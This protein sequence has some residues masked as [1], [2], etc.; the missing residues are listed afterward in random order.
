M[1]FDIGPG[2][3][4]RLLEAGAS[5]FNISYIFLSHFHP[6]HCADLI[7]FLFSNTYGSS[8][9]YGTYRTHPLTLI[10]GTG[11]EAF[12]SQLQAAYGDWIWRSPVDLKLMEMR[13][14]GPDEARFP[15][16]TLQTMPMSHKPE[17]IGFR[18]TCPD[19][20]CMVYSGDTDLCEGLVELSKRADLLICE[21]SLPDDQKV[22]GHLTPS[23]AGQTASR[24]RVKRLM[25]TH[26][27]PPC[28]LGDV[29][30]ECRKAYSGPLTLAE[31]LMVLTLP[32]TGSA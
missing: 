2:T 14:D 19:S 32:E 22:A 29:L 23:L 28:D 21:A 11:G 16:F 20:T 9:R 10:T 4:R 27:Y 18:V 26:F 25:L 13:A 1:L 12:F 6:D 30:G 31:D 5:I 15:T 7:P 24:A 8:E 17:S 3:I